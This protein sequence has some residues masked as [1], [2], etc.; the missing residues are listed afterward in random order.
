[1]LVQSSLWLCLGIVR[2]G[3]SEGQYQVREDAG[4]VMV[5]VQ[6]DGGDSQVS[7][8]VYTVDGTAYG[9]HAQDSI[10]KRISIA[11]ANCHLWY[12]CLLHS[13]FRL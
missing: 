6:L 9:N 5:P 7:L 11:F 1:M 13:F 12:A 3:F 2:V 4:R 10:S 8:R